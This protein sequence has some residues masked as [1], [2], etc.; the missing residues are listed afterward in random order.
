LG[1][2]GFTPTGS[3]TVSGIAAKPYTYTG[4]TAQTTYDWYVR[5]DCG[6]GE[7][8]PWVGP[9]TFQTTGDPLSGNY[10]IN[11]TLP[12]GGT[13][14]AS[15]T[16]L[17]AALNLGGFAGPVIVDVVTGTGPYNEQVIL[18][19]LPNSSAVNTL[20]INGNS[21]T[22]EFLSLNTNE[23]ATFKLDGTDYVT[24]DNLVI[25]AL[26]SVTGEFGWAVWLTNNADYNIFSNCSFI[27]DQTAT[28]TNFAG[29][30]TTN[31]ATT[32]TTAG[33]AAS[34]L[35]VINCQVIGGYYGMIING[36]SA[37]P[38]SENNLITGNEVK[39]FHLYGIYARG[40]NNSLITENTITRPD[41]GTTG[42]LYMIYL[43]SNMNGT[44]VTKNR[45]YDF[46]PATATTSTGYGIYATTLSADT[47]LEL[48]IAN[49]VIY[50]YQNMNSIQYGM[51]FSTSASLGNLRIYHNSVSA[52][53]INHTGSSTIY[54]LYFTGTGANLDIRNN[55]ISYTTNSSGTK[56]CLYFSG[57]TQIV[58]SDYNVLHRGATSGTN[59]TGYWGTAFPTLAD[60]KTANG[61]IYD[62]NS[63]DAD[64]IFSP[65]LITPSG[66]DA[67]DMG[68]NL[69]TWV[70]DDIF[71][72]ARTATPDPGAIEFTPVSADISVMDGNL[73][74]TTECL[75]A[76]D[77]VYVTIKN[78]IG[79]TIDF[80]V[81][82]L[83]IYWEVDG[84]ASSFGTILINNG[85]LDVG[86]NLTAGN[87]GV[88]MSVPG[89]YVLSKAY[90]QPGALNLNA[91][92]DTIYDAATI[93]LA[94]YLFDAQPDYTLI[95]T[96]AQTVELTVNSNLFA[97]GSFFITEICHFKTATGAPVG[98][99]PTYLTADD[100]IEITGVPGT[101]LGGYTLEIW[102]ASVLSGSQV[103][104]AGTVIGPG[105]TCILAVGQLG[106]S[107]PSPA[108]YYY[109]SG[110]TAS[111][112][113]TGV[114]GYIIKDS[115]GTIVDAVGYG[116]YTFPP[117]AGVT[118]ADWS[119]NTPIQSSSGIRLVGP[120]TK[121]ATNWINSAVSPQ[122]PNTVNSGVTP[123]SP[124][125]LTNFTWSLDGVI[126]S[127]NNPDTI[128]GPWT[129]DGIY[130]YVATY[131]NAC[132][133]FIDT[134]V[135]EVL[136]P[137]LDLELVEVI[138][139]A[140]EVCSYGTEDVSI[141]LTNLGANP[142]AVPFSASYTVDNGAPVT[143]TVNLVVAPADTVI[144]TFATPVSVPFTGPDTSFFLNVYVNLTGDPFQWNDTIGYNVAF[145][146]AP[147]APVGVND[148]VDFGETATLE[149]ISTYDVNWY[150]TPTDQEK[151]FTGQYFT[152]P[153][154]FATTPFYAAA[155]L[156]G[157]S[158]FVGPLDPSIG[159]SASFTAT[160]QFLIFDVLN[161]SG[162]NIKTVDV[163]PTVAAGAA[164]TMVIQDA[165]QQVIWSFPGVTTVA[166]NTKE[167][168]Q[169]DAEIPFGSGYRFGFSV[170]PGMTRNSTGAVYP[171]TL[172]GEVSITGNTFDPNYYY[173]F[174]NWE[175]GAGTG[176][177]SDRT[178]VLAVVNM[179]NCVPIITVNIDNITPTSADLSWLPGGAETAWEIEFGPAGFV[180]TGVP[181]HFISI[182]PSLALTG[183]TP[184]TAYDFYI[185]SDCGTEY[186]DWTGPHSFQ[187]EYTSM[188]GLYTINS[189]LPTSGTN[190]ASFND[191]IVAINLAGLG[192][193]V[194]VDVVA[195][196]GPYAEQVFFGQIPNGSDINTL[197]INGNGEILQFLS[198][199]TNERATLKFN[200]TDYV[201]LDN[202]VIVALGSGHGR[203]WMGS[204]V[205]QQCRFQYF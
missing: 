159:A 116:T 106:S 179:P 93:T 41:R 33:L 151:L 83:T 134:A 80:S 46:S 110:H 204:V 71:G 84:P 105:N 162:I 31:S 81:D 59:N 19:E 70:P 37:G 52:D 78:V 155:A 196:T 109:H 79:N 140:P 10:T 64:P 171:Y 32:P 135:I 148:T 192:G 77:S 163:Y 95:T 23:R 180:P 186:S 130:N 147:P 201:T 25:K 44:Q 90:I 35:K 144:Y 108:D 154:L 190:F 146:F 142:I 38:Y 57:T 121:D 176:C 94:P 170:N 113:S 7:L 200:G 194:T 99:W 195:G 82:P 39:N 55:I 173:F 139:P 189:T 125:G 58:T 43:T 107:V 26:G 203:V 75:S 166:A 160:I 11:S 12:T 66:G 76:N 202:L 182:N 67:N 101:D 198:T 118:P 48:L 120:Y 42:T 13:N 185:R 28:L 128:V 156:G 60:W 98:G 150:A 191:L 158:A 193:P 3:P 133:T 65:P 62:Q 117:A 100:Y 145:L 187:T 53:N 88:D 199:N 68:T 127:Y 45:I 51:Y 4:L 69:L 178:E 49:N 137:Q 97:G 129:V 174:Y 181:T 183:L 61:G 149:A 104:G 161:P 34:N 143:E 89:T 86:N 115:G 20:T 126:T 8:S 112:S 73:V 6:A 136:I 29:F 54:G 122:D 18:G 16:D 132:G 165:S 102:T 119:G 177:E 188:S 36:P 175:V 138:S 85:T 141:A 197:T 1:L 40:Q 17:A 91:S 24:V 169:I 30:V 111:Q 72:V 172:P 92:N 74:K 5:A 152:T 96:S 27:A 47:G 63:I 22:L 2:T 14:F 205:D 168:V 114:A 153:P 103:L 164:Y 21:E 123:P 167:T 15:F 9:H 131:T 87:N 50:G 157:G 56:Y 124:G 184:A